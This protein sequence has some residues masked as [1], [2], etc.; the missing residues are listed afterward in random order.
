MTQTLKARIVKSEF[1]RP[2]KADGGGHQILEI[3]EHET[4]KIEKVIVEGYPNEI[5]K[6]MRSFP[7]GVVIS[8]NKHWFS[9][10]LEKE[11]SIKVWLKRGLLF[12]K[13][14]KIEYVDRKT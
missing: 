9:F 12:Y 7:E 5:H 10:Y 11:N 4:K 1:D 13:I 6:A 8:Y 3:E 2:L 14:K